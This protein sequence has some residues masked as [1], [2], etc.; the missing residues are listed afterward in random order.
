MSTT[1]ARSSGSPSTTSRRNRLDH[2]RRLTPR[3]HQLLAWLAEHYI[4]TTDQ[5]T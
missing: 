2:L 3:D 1:S 4:L 5:T